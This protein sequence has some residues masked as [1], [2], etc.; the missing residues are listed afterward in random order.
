MT[1][2]VCGL[3]TVTLVDASKE[4]TYEHM[5]GTSVGGTN[6]TMVI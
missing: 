5:L 2:A 1:F 3:E 4:I 6:T